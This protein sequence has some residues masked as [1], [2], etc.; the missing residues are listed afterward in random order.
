MNRY[1]AKRLEQ[2]KAAE[3][4]RATMRDEPRCW[5]CGHGPQNPRPGQPYHLNNIAGHEIAN[6]QNRL[7]CMGLACGVLA[8]CQ[9][10]N[11]YEL[12]NKAKW[13][14]SRQLAVLL[15]RAPHSFNLPKYLGTFY[16]RAPN[17]VTLQEVLQ[18][19]TD[20]PWDEQLDD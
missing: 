15:A 3:P 9:W 16:P 19:G 10:C 5:V 8:A 6:G 14:E 7:R 12:T 20:Y 18:W 2:N 1:T 11:L 4:F 17:R 13:P